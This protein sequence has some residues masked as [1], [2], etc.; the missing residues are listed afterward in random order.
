MVITNEYNCKVSLN[1]KILTDD[2]VAKKFPKYDRGLLFSAP[3][4]GLYNSRV[5]A[6]RTTGES[7]L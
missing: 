4:I 7:R 5:I 3:C 2:L 6:F 1:K